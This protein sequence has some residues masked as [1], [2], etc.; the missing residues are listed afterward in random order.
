MRKFFLTTFFLFV[1]LQTIESQATELPTPTT[2]YTLSLHTA[3]ISSVRSR[4]FPSQSYESIASPHLI[5]AGWDGLIGI[6][7]LTNGV[8]EGGEDGVIE[9]GER[10]KRRKKTPKGV[11][12]NKVSRRSLVLHYSSIIH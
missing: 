1:L 2:L 5:T 11:A 4:S 6:W 9:G 7:D 10:K 3:P 12:I 8:N